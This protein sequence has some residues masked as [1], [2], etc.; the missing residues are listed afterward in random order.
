M[1]WRE[2]FVY[3]LAVDMPQ[4]HQL[5]H[6]DCLPEKR[7]RFSVASRKSGTYLWML[8]V[9]W[10]AVEIRQRQDSNMQQFDFQALVISVVCHNIRSVLVSV[11]EAMDSDFL[12]KN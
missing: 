12:K 4:Y 10:P 1:Y 8:L 9:R 3:R 2:K 11:P 5:H 7:D 6:L